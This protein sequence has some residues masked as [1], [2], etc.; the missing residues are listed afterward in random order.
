MAEGK[1]MSGANY[2]VRLCPSVCGL[3]YKDDI[4]EF[5]HGTSRY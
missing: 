4:S 1:D 2:G 3:L 5:A